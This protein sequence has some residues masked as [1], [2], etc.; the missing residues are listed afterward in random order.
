MCNLDHFR[1]LNQAVNDLDSRGYTLESGEIV[2]AY[3]RRN[4]FGIQPEM[5]I[6]RIFQSAFLEA[7]IQHNRITLPAA[8]AGFWKDPLEN[9]LANVAGVDEVTGTGIDYGSL[10]RPFHALCWTQRE[11]AS[12]SDWSSFSHGKP[13]TRITTSAGKLMRQ[14]FDRDDPSYMHRTWLVEVEYAKE[15]RIKALQNPTEALNRM[16]STGALLALS[17]A[18]VRSSFSDES[19]VRLLCD[20]SLLPHPSGVTLDES[21]G[22]VHIP[23]DWND[24]IEKREDAPP[25]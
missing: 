13:A 14:L 12:S 16:E 15:D 21:K 5:K 3:M 25:C 17:A 2:E 18:T 23:F 11:R 22:L 7:D 8:S 4:M 9:P 10:V 20:T 6:Y 19:E 1:R 24:F